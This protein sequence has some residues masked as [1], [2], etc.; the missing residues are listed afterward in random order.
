MALTTV[1]IICWCRAE[2]ERM[3]KEIND[4][5][6]GKLRLIDDKGNDLTDEHVKGER[7]RAFRLQH[8]LN[9]YDTEKQ[10]RCT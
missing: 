5:A 9:V 7:E 1:D 6:S 8:L 4:L 2:I 10:K 3:S